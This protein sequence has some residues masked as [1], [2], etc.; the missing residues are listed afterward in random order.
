MIT[1]VGITNK[2]GIGGKNEALV[3]LFFDELAEV[4]SLPTTE[5]EDIGNIAVHSLALCNETGKVYQ[6]NGN[7]QWVLVGGQ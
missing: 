5:L 7:R 6:L 2:T 3:S 4:T 1:V